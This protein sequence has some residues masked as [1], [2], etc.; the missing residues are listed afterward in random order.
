MDKLIEANLYRNQLITINGKLVERYNTCLQTLGFKETLLNTFSIDGLGWSP[1]IAEE[2]QNMHY[3]NNGDANP[4]AILITPRQKDIPVYMPF[5]SFDKK[6]MKF[7]F[8]T[9]DA[10]I[11]DITRD[12]AICIDFDQ[13][14]DTFYEP[15]DILKYQEISIGFRITNNIVT[16]QKTQFD[17][18]NNFR[19]GHNFIDESMHEQLLESAKSYGDLRHRNFIMSAIAFDVDSFYS[20]AFG[21][22]YVLRE[23]ITPIVIFR[24]KENYNEAIKDVVHDILIYHVGQPELV[25]KL[26]D[27]MILECDLR[28]EVQSER[29][30]RIKKFELYQHLDVVEHSFLEILDDKMLFKS[31]LNKLSVE[32]RKKVMCVERYLDKLESSNAYKIAD[33]VD[34]EIYFS[35]HRPHS[36]LTNDQKDLIWKLLV[37]I[38]AKDILYLFWYDKS[39]FHDAFVQWKPTFKD[40]AVKT[41]S[42]NI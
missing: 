1:E 40:W 19:Q 13:D 20:K 14:I 34:D 28:K 42:N 4:H 11:K 21:G 26:R 29:Y 16:H 10:Q 15:L 25:T 39:K 17:L 37:N 31:Y 23:F 22:V 3:L 5:H 9:Y 2:R 8:D 24:D 38:S 36:S 32:D 6:M 30:L 33:L 7:V 27:H 41:I 35:L 18:I 12:Q